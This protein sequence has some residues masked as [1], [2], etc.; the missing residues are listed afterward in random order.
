MTPVMMNEEMMRY[1]L[2]EL[3]YETVVPEQEGWNFRIQKKGFGYLKGTAGLI[4]VAL[5]IGLEMAGKKEE[6]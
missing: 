1:L 2:E 5:S 6:S 3:S 4:Q